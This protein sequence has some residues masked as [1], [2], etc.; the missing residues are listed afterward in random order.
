MD[1][2][3]YI[4]KHPLEPLYQILRYECETSTEFL[5]ILQYRGGNDFVF[6][7]VIY[8]KILNVPFLFQISLL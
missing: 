8:F 7:G 4:N 1:Y 3:R 5:I 6:I 2:V